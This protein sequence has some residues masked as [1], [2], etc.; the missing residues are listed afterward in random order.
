M[1]P[2]TTLVLA[3]VAAALGAFIWFYEIEG[4]ASRAESERAGKRIFSGLE[5]DDVDW[6]ALRTRDGVEARLERGDDRRWSL[7]APIAFA[8]DEAI[9]DGMASALAEL[10]PVDEIESAQAASVYGLGDDARVIRFGARGEERALRIGRDA[11]VG[12]ARYV[13]RE[14]DASV[15]TIASW[16]AN[17]F[18]KDFAALRDARVLAFDRERVVGLTARWPG[19]EVA[20]AKQD[21]AWRL[22]APLDAPADASRIAD[23]LSD[24]AY[25]RAEGFVDEPSE[26]ERASLAAPDFELELALGAPAGEPAGEPEL[27][28]AFALGREVDGARLVR[29]GGSTL[30]RVGADRIDDFPRRTVEYRDRTLSR[31]A[32][33]DAER[34]EIAFHEEGAQ[35]RSEVVELQRDEGAWTSTP[36]LR[37]G[38]ASAL[39]AALSQLTADD[40]DAEWLGEEER[41][42]LGLAPE[43][44][45]LRVFGA[46][47]S[48]DG[49]PAE[50]PLLADV[51]LGEL[52]GE[53]RFAAMA[54]GRDT[55]FRLPARAADDLPLS[56][57]DF[58]ARFVAPPE[59]AAQ[60]AD[61]GDEP[62]SEG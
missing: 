41:R 33:G 40:I 21:G 38:V 60:P 62:G 59:P 34:V 46:P 7:S 37:E 30:F 26:A 53:R 1:N 61:P 5:A 29:T 27:P 14:G 39:V 47:A 17:A 42:A 16:R 4:E 22:T 25:L 44:V 3:L 15:F 6:V 12:A 58:E 36:A 23:L 18:D 43:R 48:G 51:L 50:A 54:R 49:A 20:L 31:F 2:R 32:I 8:A 10:D 28:L 9:A 52:D 56:R 55:L 11:P 19:G 45:A 13:A 57:A 35:A 24:L